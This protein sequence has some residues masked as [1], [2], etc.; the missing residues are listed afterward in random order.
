MPVCACLCRFVPVCAGLCN[1]VPLCAFLLGLKL[2]PLS[3]GAPVQKPPFP[4]K[5]LFLVSSLAFDLVEGRI[6]IVRI[7]RRVVVFVAATK[8]TRPRR[9]PP[10]RHIDVVIWPPPPPLPLNPPLVQG[11][12]VHR[13]VVAP[14]LRVSIVV[15]LLLR[16]TEGVSGARRPRAY[17]RIAA[18]VD[19]AAVVGATFVLFR[20][21]RPPPGSPR[22]REGRR[23]R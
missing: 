15:L 8:K 19:V 7:S 20:R 10:D 22:G 16:R 2:P 4:P 9:P 11:L 18:V 12:A 14:P 23:G 21:R 5:K 1:F 17:T 3:V 13:A 6:I